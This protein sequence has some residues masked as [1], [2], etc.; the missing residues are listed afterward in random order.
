MRK[1]AH[2]LHQSLVHSSRIFK[3]EALSAYQWMMIY[4]AVLLGGVGLSAV[5]TPDRKWWHAFFSVLGGGGVVAA[6]IF[7]GT[8]IISGVLLG[9]VG[10]AC[11]AKINLPR[12]RRRIQC[13]FWLMGLGL[14]TA[15]IIPYDHIYTI[16]YMAANLTALGFI[17]LSLN[18]GN[19]APHLSR[20]FI[21]FNYTVIA[22]IIIMYLILYITHSI[23]MTVM[24]VA[25]GA[26]F[27]LWLE[28]FVFEI[29]HINA[30]RLNKKARTV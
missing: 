19:T 20:N 28:R 22:G 3:V 10:T 30:R 18:L 23:T 12:S 15:G 16:H 27:L 26:L 8:L 1:H 5:V 29:D 14:M 11:A 7:N 4:I 13:S 25:I 6:Q 17:M 2:L 9:V 24:E 21:I